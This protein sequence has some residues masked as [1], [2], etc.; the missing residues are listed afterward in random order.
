[1]GMEMGQEAMIPVFLATGTKSLAW[2]SETQ[3]RE[4][5]VL[6]LWRALLY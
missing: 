3:A 6:R 2:L 4:E 1:M 5:T